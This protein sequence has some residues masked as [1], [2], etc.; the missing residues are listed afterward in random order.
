MLSFSSIIKQI[1][2][3]DGG[4]IEHMRIGAQKRAKLEKTPQKVAHL[5]MESVFVDTINSSDTNLF[6]WCRRKHQIF[7]NKYATDP[8]SCDIFEQMFCRVQRA[9]YGFARLARIWRLRKSPVQISC[10]L[11]MTPLDPSH[12][13]TFQLLQQNN[14]YYF[15][16]RDL[17]K[18]ITNSITN[19]AFLFSD[20]KV[21]KNPYNN[22]VFSKADLY[23]MYWKIRESM[24]IVPTIIDLWFR[25]GFDVYKLR[26]CHEHEFAEYA[27]NNY[28]NTLSVVQMCEEIYEMI[29]SLHFQEVIQPIPT[30]SAERFS[31]DFK[32]YLRLFLKVQ[33]YPDKIVAA[34]LRRELICKLRWFSNMYPYYGRIQAQ[35]PP[36]QPE[37]TEVFMRSHQYSEAQYTN[38]IMWGKYDEIQ[39]NVVPR[40][41]LTLT[42]GQ[43]E[44]QNQEEDQE[45][46]DNEEDELSEV[47][48]EIDEDYFDP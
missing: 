5:L 36:I 17:C 21:A 12:K 22:I 24:C 9:Y 28:V 43:D 16:T 14:I 40:L 18:L 41:V 19:S 33:Y 13:H 27:I 4:V 37:E 7:T 29:Y 2:L 31:A 45:Q 3:C 8:I 32:P 46:D 42:E 44:E 48:T 47:E 23:N 35:S 20:P 11:F 38:Y 34:N 39:R 6:A 26:K 15:S 25:Y 1:H 10:D 30:F